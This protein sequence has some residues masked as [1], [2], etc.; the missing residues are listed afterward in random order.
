VVNRFDITIGAAPVLFTPV[1][2]G[3]IAFGIRFPAAAIFAGEDLSLGELSDFDAARLRENRFCS[4]FISS[5]LCRWGRTSM[6]DLGR[7][8]GVQIDF[9]YRRHL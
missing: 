5:R 4:G 6:A 7:S 9:E 2:R 8:H 1:N 3:S